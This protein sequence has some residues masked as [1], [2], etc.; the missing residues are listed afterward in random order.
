MTEQSLAIKGQEVSQYQLQER[1]M[2]H[3]LKYMIVNG[4][5]LQEHEVYALAQYAIATNLDPLAL[6][7]WYFPGKGPTPGIAGWR[8]KAQEQ[9][10]YESGQHNNHFWCEYSDAK[11]TDGVFDKNKDIAI[12]VTLRDSVTQTSWRKAILDVTIPLIREGVPSP[13][14]LKVARELV[15]PEPVWTACGVVFSTENFGQVEKFDRRERAK[16]RGEKLALRKRFP[17]IH[18]VEPEGSDSS[19]EASDFKVIAD[20][21][22]QFAPGQ[23]MRELGFETDEPAQEALPVE[24]TQPEPKKQEQALRPYSPAALKERIQIM[25]DSFEG[26][27]CT[28]GQRTSVKINLVS[29][30]GG[31]DNG[32]TLLKWLVGNAHVS[33]LTD[34]QVLAILKWIHVKKQADDQWIPDEW[35]IQEAHAA[36]D[37]SLKAQ[38]QESLL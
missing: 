14:A 16:K 36:F 27:T 1:R 38:G 6:E 12:L 31:E 7:C 37:E 28:E 8:R 9:M 2:I 13:E 34:A 17:R 32:R 10:E 20:E 18:L 19:F 30:A 22:R 23:A 4:T 15:G 25:V 11:E 33:E 35:S 24:T 29:M 26:K 21:P 5:K 3:Q